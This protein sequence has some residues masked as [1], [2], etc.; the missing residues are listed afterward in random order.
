ME[1]ELG[2]YI[3]ADAGELYVSDKKKKIFV[4]VLYVIHR[5]MCIQRVRGIGVSCELLI[6]AK[7][8]CKKKNAHFPQVD[9]T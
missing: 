8:K 1:I 2:R 5:H 9:C 3:R 7:L 4:R 6:N